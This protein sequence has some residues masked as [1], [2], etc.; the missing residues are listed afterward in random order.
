MQVILTHEQADF[1]AVA[2]LLGAALLQKKALAVLPNAMNRNVKKFVHLYAADLPFIKMD[3]L[4]KSTIDCVTLVDTQSLITLKGV[5]KSTRV[6]VIDHH[7]KRENL[8]ETW[9]FMPVA[10]NA[11]ATHFVEMLQENNDSLNLVQATLFLLG[12]YEDTGSLTYANTTSKDVMAVAY[13]LDQGASLKIASDFLN[14]PL[15]NWQR[16]VFE[17][18]VASMETITIHNCRISISAAKAPDLVDEVSSIAHKLSD[19]SDPD[20]LF[21]FVE[22]KE[23]IR[24]VARSITDQIDARIITQ[25][26]GGGGHERAAAA[27]IKRDKKYEHQLSDTVSL[28]KKE[29]P[30]YV[31][32]AITVKQIMSKKPLTISPATSAEE[33]HTLMKNYGYE[34]YPVIENGQIT[35]LLTRR[36]VDRALSH[37]LNLPASSLMEAGN[38]FVFPGDSLETIQKVMADSGWGQIPVLDPKSNLII[39]IA[40]R[41]DLLRMIAGKKSSLTEKINLATEMES[42]LAPARLGLLKLISLAS[43][44]L[45]LPIYLVGGFARDLLLE[46]AGSDMDFVVEGDGILL[47]KALAEKYGGRVTTHKKFGTAKWHI[48]TIKKALLDHFS[49]V[50]SLD[51]STLPPAIDLISARTEFYERPTALP[52]VKTGSIKLDLH[53]RDFTINTMAVRLDGHHFGDL[54]DYWGGLN[55]LKK[56]LIR[57][58]HSLSFVDDP[59]RILRAVRFEQRF[60]FNIEDRTLALITE[61]KDLLNE[62]SGNRI[63]HE[64]D[65]ILEESQAPEMLARINSLNL[66]HPFF[67]KL[68]WDP[69]TMKF[70]RK[71]YQEKLPEAWFPQD[72]QNNIL[73]K[74]NG[75]YILLMAKASQIDILKILQWLRLKNHLAQMIIQTNLLWHQLSSLK[76]LTPSQATK[77]LE[78]YSQLEIYCVWL[79]CSDNQIRKTLEGFAQKWRWIKPFTDG[80]ALLKRGL[81]PGPDYTDILQQLKAAWLDEKIKSKEEEFQYLNNLLEEKPD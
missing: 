6:D 70:L 69:E 2:S 48:A 50:T 36:A 17:Q 11:C 8:S 57:V 67:A 59:T 66:F 19:L 77:K 61:A 47:A 45:N 81:K 72:Y 32:P 13:L 20:G 31:K 29:L 30:K 23:G 34:G 42:N 46:K 53:R 38:I 64:L 80:S 18:L 79:L 73:K 35:G 12:I 65:L 39:G 52:T 3:E 55:D 26:F 10:T 37:K 4:P 51:Y 9:N 63:R 16:V 74:A 5:N 28:F 24:L 68:K 33:A 62:V 40:T 25:Q 78:D 1:D 21:I 7:L 43:S 71:Y 58:L 27:L 49:A 15:S 56:G 76:R 44:N 41:T 14:P 75:A 60:G 22:T 54:Y